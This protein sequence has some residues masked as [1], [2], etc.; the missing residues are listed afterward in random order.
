MN[1][2]HAS[3]YLVSR[4]FA[5]ALNLISVAT[6]TRLAP[7]AVFGDYLVGFATGFI[8]FGTAFQWLL[9]AHFGV[10]APERAARLAGALI[11]LLGAVALPGLA[12]LIGAI[13]LGI[14]DIA[15]GF[16]IVALVAGLVLHIAAIEI[17]RAHLLVGAV[18]AAS[19]LRGILML[20]FGCA[21]LLL[22]Q[23][24]MALLVAIGLAH[25]VAAVPVLLALHRTIWRAG[26]VPPQRADILDLLTYGWPLILA[27]MAG[28]ISINLDR[29]ALSWWAG[30]GAVGPYGAVADIIRQS[31][32]V[33]GEAIAAAY[34]SQ[35][36]AQM[37]DSTA[38][39]AIL[40]RA[41]VTL[42]VIVVFGVIGFALFGAGVIGM[43][44]AP[45]YLD[46]ALTAMPILVLGTA[47]LVLRA[48]YFGQVIYFT[49]SA[50]REV[51]ASVL[52]LAIAIIGCLTLVPTFGLLGAAT[53]F[54]ATQAAGLSYFLWADRRSAIMPIDWRQ[55]GI[56]IAAATG[57]CLIA[58]LAMLALGGALGWF[59]GLAL[60]LA[61]GL[62]LAVAWNLFDLGRLAAYLLARLAPSS[63]RS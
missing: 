31:F 63:R 7:P 52:M 24:A 13:A 27:L 59:A 35:A 20:G 28:A 18:T 49:G 51:Q 55:A 8:V 58:F 54:G 10:Y 12:L 39:R 29:I 62:A 43:V 34:V 36:K 32:V 3:L 41:F 40:Q 57:T 11:A 19:L 45:D 26:F 2:R 42:W 4:I 37:T 5:A 21:A 9:H 15:Q 60:M 14:V 47:C 53:T 30:P 25:L 16:G 17:G 56:A 61:G 23:D 1:D 33:L 6:F 22:M 50:R 44:L 46:T 48:Y 38:A